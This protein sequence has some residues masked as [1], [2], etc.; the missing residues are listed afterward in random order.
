MVVYKKLLSEG[1]TLYTVIQY[2]YYYNNYFNE[3]KYS[4]VHITE[5]EFLLW[6]LVI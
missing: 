6:N 1:A 3:N 5:N 4:N 2:I